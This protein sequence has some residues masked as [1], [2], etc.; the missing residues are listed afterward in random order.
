MWAPGRIPVSE[1]DAMVTLV[2]V[3]PTILETLDLPAAEGISG[4]SLSR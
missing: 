2:D 4:Q 1:S 3:L